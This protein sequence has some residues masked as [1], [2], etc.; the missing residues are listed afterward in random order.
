[1]RDQGVDAARGINPVQVDPRSKS[2]F[3]M[4]Q[5]AEAAGEGIGNACAAVRAAGRATG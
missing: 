5:R 2:K 3:L 4:R 1:M